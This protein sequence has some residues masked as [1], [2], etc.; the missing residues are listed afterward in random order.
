MTID[1][2]KAGLETIGWKQTDFA[3]S[4]G[5]S[6]V[7]VTQWVSGKNPLPPWAAN[8]L[9]ML[10]KLH[11][12]RHLLESGLLEPPTKVAK[13]SKKAADNELLE[14]DTK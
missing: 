11:E 7:A 4:I 13:A 10:L 1:E 6:K 8:Y 9:K 2:F 14:N 5:L 12:I 3:L